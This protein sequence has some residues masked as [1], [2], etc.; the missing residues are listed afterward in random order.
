MTSFN[1]SG[2]YEH[3]PDLAARVDELKG[4]IVVAKSGF[5][6]VPNGN[7]L[8][9]SEVGGAVG[10]GEGGKLDGV[11]SDPG[12]LGL[13]DGEIDNKRDD[14]DENQEDGGN[15]AR[16]QV[17][18]A[19]GWWPETL[20]LSHSLSLSSTKSGGSMCETVSEVMGLGFVRILSFLPWGVYILT[21]TVRK[22]WENKRT[23]CMGT[24]NKY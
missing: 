4:A 19:R 22:R 5:I 1:L 24:K 7:I 3:E 12:F 21:I 23:L 20:R 15:Y 13:E 11:D 6:G 10:Y 8:R 2:R 9:E 14:D 16:G 17:G 18:T